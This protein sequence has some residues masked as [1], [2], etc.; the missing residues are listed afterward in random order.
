LGTQYILNN[1]MSRDRLDELSPDVP[2]LLM[3][4]P[5]WQLNTK[6]QQVFFGMY[7]VKPTDEAEQ[8]IGEYTTFRRSLL[9][10]S[11]FR[12]HLDELANIIEEA[13][14]HQAALGFTSFASHIE[15][16]RVHDAYQIL[17]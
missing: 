11:Y 16:Q 12:N 4:A 9:I 7:G 3:G 2:V 13:M 6:A 1:V 15:P 14:M 17:V 5:M 8:G 10:D